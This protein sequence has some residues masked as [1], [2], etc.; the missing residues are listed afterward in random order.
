MTDS[1]QARKHIQA[2]TLRLR[3]G[4]IRFAVVAV[5]VVLPSAAATVRWGASSVGVGSESRPTPM[6]KRTIR[7][8]ATPEATTKTSPRAAQSV[9][10]GIS[11]QAAVA[12]AVGE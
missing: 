1:A 4:P 12:T 10:I 7:P 9:C 2:V 11:V 6:A 3:A 8:T 5:V